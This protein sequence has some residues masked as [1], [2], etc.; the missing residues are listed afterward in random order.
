MPNPSSF[1][2]IFSCRTP[3]P[4]SMR[5][6]CAPH[7]LCA[8]VRGF[9]GRLTRS[10]LFRVAWGVEPRP[11]IAGGL[12]DGVVS[13]ASLGPSVGL[14][15][16]VVEWSRPTTAGERCLSSRPR[17]GLRSPSP[18][19]RRHA[20]PRTHCGL[21]AAPWGVTLFYHITKIEPVMRFGCPSKFRL[22][23]K[24][25]NLVHFFY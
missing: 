9:S 3:Q 5:V 21:P 24:N 17:T 7:A 20:R 16:V 19:L 15:T 22:S 1:C 11:G 18:D 25:C 2:Q 14:P 8:R 4:H 13:A 6:L 10:S 12:A 23:K